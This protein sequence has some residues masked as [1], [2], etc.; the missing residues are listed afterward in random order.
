MS[1]DKYSKRLESLFSH[2]EPVAPE[3]GQPAA[4]PQ[5]AHAQVRIAELEAAVAEARQQAEQEHAQRLA[6]SAALENLKAQ[7]AK[8]E[9]E[10]PV[11]TSAE[12]PETA[13]SRASRLRSAIQPLV[14]RRQASEADKAQTR[15]RNAWRMAVILLVTLAVFDVNSIYNILQTQAPQQWMAAGLSFAA[16][17]GMLASAW[18]IRRERVIPG[19]WTMILTVLAALVLSPPLGA[20]LGLVYA[21]T[22]IIV[23]SVVAGQALPP[24][25][26]S[27]AVTAGILFAIAT[28]LVDLFWPFPRPGAGSQGV[29]LTVLGGLLV[30][31]VFIVARQYRD[32]GLRTKVALGILLTAGAALA[33]L[34]FFAYDQAQRVQ[35]FLIGQLQTAVG[36]QAEQ[37]LSN[38]VLAE[39]RTADRTLSNVTDDVVALADYRGSLEKQA[40]TLGKGAYWDGHSRL[41]RLSGGQYGNLSTDVASIFIPSTF[42]L[43]EALIADLN[44][45]AYLDFVGPAL[46][47]AHPNVVAI[48]FMNARGAT[49]YYPNISL[50]AN[51][52]PDF[53]PTVQPFFLVANPQNNPERQA[54]WTTP[55]QDPAG[56]GLIVTN[57]APVYDGGGQFKGIIAA[58]V[59]L[60]KISEQIATIEVGQS[61]FAFLVDRAGRI[62]AMPEAGYKL[63]DLRPET[64]PV[65]EPPKQSVLGKGPTDLQKV[66]RRMV[67]GETGLA[68]VTLDGVQNYVAYAPLPAV[69]YSLGLVVP[70]AELTAPSLTAQTQIQS[71]TQATLRL[72]G[73]LLVGLLVGAA[74]VSLGIGQ[75][76][77][78]PVVRLTQTAERVTAGDL[79]AQ[80]RV[81]SGDESGV[82]AQVFNAMTAQLRETLAGLEER[83]SERTRDLSLAA[84]VGQRLAAVRDLDSLLAEAVELIRARFDL[85]YTQIYLTNPTGAALELR[86]GTGEV[87]KELLRRAHR[88]PIGPGSL[89]G[90]AASEKQAVIV[91]D[92]SISASFRPNPLLPETRSEMAVPLTAGGRVVGVLDL[93]S[94]MP[95]ALTEDNLSAFQALAGQLA[96]AIQNASLFA[97]AQQA[98]AEVEAQARRLTRSGWAEF[99][100]AVDRSERLGFAYD[101]AGLAP[102]NEPLPADGDQT[103]GLARGRALAAPITVAGEPVGI[104]RLE[105]DA[106]RVWTPAE[107]EL[108]NLVARQVAQQ[109]ENLRLLAQAE[110]ARAEAEEATRRLAREGWETYLESTPLG[111]GF[112]YD[113]NQ[114]VPL[115]QTDTAARDEAAGLARPLTVH[116]EVIGQLEVVPPDAMTEAE[117]ELVAAVTDRL[118]AHIENLRLYAEAETSAQQAQTLV[119]HAPEAIVV[120]DVDTGLFIEPNRNAELLYGLSRDELLKVGPAEMSPLVQPDGRPSLEKAIEKITEAMQ[121]GA[122]VFEWMHR[123][124]QGDD[125]PCEVRLV[126]MPSPGRNLV[127]ASVTDITERKRAE[128]TLRR[129][130]AYLAALQETT[131]GLVGRLELT[132]LLETIVTR[133]GELMGTRHGYIFLLEPGGTEMRMHVGTGTYHSFIG[134][135]LKPGQAVVGTIWETGDPL[136]I[137][138]YQNWAKHLSLQNLE[139]V[140]AVAGAPLKSGSQVMGVIG[141]AY[142]EEDRRFGEDEVAVL[143]RFAQLASVALDNARLFEQTQQRATEL[144]EA[145]S[146]LDSVIENLPTMLFVKDAHELRF[147]RWNEAGEE[148][149]GFQRED[150][151]G[152]NDY[153]FFPKEEADFFV[154]KDKEVLAGGKLVDIPEE[155]IQTAHRGLRYLHTRK[156]PVL[157]ADGKPRYLLGI[158]EDITERKQAEAALAK[159]AVE[160]ATVAE[161]STV[162]STIL[163]AE[164]LLQEVVD[165]TKSRF[166][167][168][169]AHIYL[170]DE[171]AETLNLA[172]GAGEVGQQMVA[173]QHTIP[174][175]R[176]QSL[177]ARAARTRQG[178]IVNDVQVAPDFLPNPLLPETRSEMALPLIVGE[179]VLGVFDVQ[180]EAVNRFTEEDLR[181]QTTLAGQ[182]AVALQNANLYAEQTATVTRLR[183][184]DQLKSSF[185]ANMSHE[186]RTPL[187]SIIGFTDVMLEGINGPLTELMDNDLQVVRKNGQHLLNLINDVLDMAKIEA[188]RLSLSVETF[189]LLEVLSEVLDITSPLAREKLLDLRLDMDYHTPIELVADRFRLRQVM[190][191]LVNNAIKFTDE[192]GI[193]LRAVKAGDDLVRIAVQDTG[194]GI[195]ASHLEAVFQEF[196]QVDT[197][198]TRKVGGTGLGLPISRH[199][200][201]MHGGR[202]WAESTGVPGEGSTFFVELPVVARL[203]EAVVA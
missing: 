111:E 180:S 89:N 132:G 88:L 176:E 25:Q 104:I 69:G 179:R 195:P 77:A 53:D 161:V 59:Q 62:I 199:L 124:A 93:Q 58:D 68:N 1:D 21:V 10:A 129:Q 57:A 118:S 151:I 201:E 50:A 187:N 147:L 63:F 28:F 177:V 130:H 160:L 7:T 49:T 98:H 117:A 32:Y 103:P 4:P 56:T 128:E 141:L 172:V 64:V 146:F 194:G 110:Q 109:V 3:P 13:P 150:L 73:I 108:V 80:A 65:N 29:T 96:I 168:Y 30:V 164:R 149:V 19:V 35:T 107:A 70:A 197:S 24:G 174:L 196:T 114:V 81:E 9:A 156:V 120:V 136:V 170:L 178:V 79:S 186:L 14:P 31:Y 75:V 143:S 154:A 41:I 192:G 100:N 51:V 92:T 66:T 153:D 112:T 5:D 191:N 167:L 46:L 71:A 101:Q 122:P 134:Y 202:L 83:V 23:A 115:A 113:L 157:G 162:A 47:K 95:G 166:N 40:L 193:T 74:I 159:R 175:N 188:G 102:L 54:V 198:I 37:Q 190:I 163:E 148:I 123:N 86:A 189:D 121:G 97:E 15:A 131:L 39:A 90:R 8:V 152:K 203:G 43:D 55:Y 133:A 34:G 183:E 142:L 33:A 181:V 82:L 135:R 105:S 26:T 106:Q 169:H 126:R 52:P 119:E 182:V 12:G 85:Y 72:A 84:E 116:G 155:P 27:W 17:L 42:T 138:D 137:D 145:T 127:R 38:I 91:A 44:T 16:S 139:P 144:E 76:I 184:I 140:R 78:A 125:I 99:L 185:L 158:S 45:S 22:G 200:I 173:Q 2:V 60:A 36:Q 94:S 165:L 18:L 61:G 11:Q 48:Y 20:G 67:V 171:A 6:A 87:G